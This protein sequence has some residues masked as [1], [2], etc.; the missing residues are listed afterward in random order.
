MFISH[1]APRVLYAA[2]DGATTGNCDSWANACTLQY[3][4]S[5][6]QNGDEIWVKA[7]VHY[8]GP[9]G[10]RMATF[11]LKSGVAIYGGFAGTESSR[12]ARDWQANPTVLSGDIDRNDRTDANGVVTTTAHITGTNAY[13]VVTAENVDS[14]AVLDGFIITA[15]KADG[16]Y[17]HSDGGGMYNFNSSP[18]LANVTFSGNSASKWGG[19]IY[20]FYKGSPTLTN[21]FFSGNSAAYGGGGICNTGSSTTLSSVIFNTNSAGNG[22]GMYNVRSNLTLT[23]VTFSGNYAVDGGG[24][25]NQG[26]SL[27]LINVIFSDNSARDLGGG[28]WNYKSNLTLSGVIFSGNRTSVGG[29]MYNS[30]S[31]LTLASITFSGNSAWRGG[32]VYNSNSSLTLTNITFS[33]NYATYGG[34]MYNS[35][36][37][38]MLTDITFSSNYSNAGGAI[39]NYYSNPMLTNVT[40]SRNTALNHGGGMYNDNSNPTL[41]NVIFSH[42]GVH[43]SGGAVYNYKSNPVLINA[44][45]NGNN[46]HFGG[47]IYNYSSDPHLINVILWGN[48]PELSNIDNSAPIISYS[49][50]R[51]CGSSGSGWKSECGVDGGGNIEADPL[52][53]DAAAGNLRLRPDSPAIDTGNEEVLLPTITTDLDKNPRISG[54]T[55]DMGAYEYQ[56]PNYYRLLV[57]LAG[58]GAGWVHSAP[59]HIACPS[60]CQRE[61]EIGAQVVLTATPGTTSQVAGWEGCD[62]VVGNICTLNMTA[63]RSVTVTFS[64]NPGILYAASIARGAGDCS[65]WANA[66]TLQI[67]LVSAAGGDEIWVE[68][69]V[70]YPGVAGTYTATITSFALKNGVAI[71]G[72]FAGTENNRDMRDWQA[73]LT[74]LSGDID[75]NDIT[76]ANGVVTTTTHLLGTNAYHVVT[77]ENVDNTAVLDGFIITAGQANGSYP[78]DKGGGMYNF[79]SNPTLR[80]I[81]FIGNSARDGGGMYNYNSN[82]TLTNVTFNNN[83]AAYGGGMHNWNSSPTLANSAF[84]DNF[85]TDGGGMHNWNS[86]PNLRNVIFTGNSATFGGGMYNNYSNPMLTDVTFNGNFADFGGGILNAASNPTLINISFHYN[87]GNGMYNFSSSPMLRNVI[88]SGNSAWSGGGVRND[89]SHPMLINVTFSHNFANYGGGMYNWCSNPTIINTT[90]SGNSAF[91]GGGMYNHSSDPHLINVILWGNTPELSN[92]D[93]SVP[94]ISYSDI[95]GCGGSGSGWKSECG[96]DGGGNI[97]ADPLFADAAAGN[98]RLRLTSP[99]IDAGDNTAVPTDIT[100]DLGG[101]PRFV[102]VPFV[103]DTGRGTPPIVDMGAYEAYIH[104]VYL[105]LIVRHY[106]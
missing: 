73:N 21:A 7:G 59:P 60:A 58:P 41:T 94:I 18:T 63:P 50:I 2:P 54:V 87:S 17:P 96:M 31:S 34:G 72:G 19:G 90:F 52:F 27:T 51:G 6:A 35:Y 67:A 29:G 99:C 8:P 4:L 83:S 12:D 71:Y 105:P 93:N 39:Y 15:G 57:N 81:T 88:F 49:D 89:Y 102:N 40:F 103:P 30:H 76:D 22:G 45:F 64:H 65:N 47:G 77:A 92:I 26:S 53:V 37:N 48:T 36:S 32:G 20:N 80:N 79:N 100:T 97:D 44:T 106:R 14:T 69:G 84:N 24:M 62:N 5:L 1:A 98:L 11:A 91:H 38:P 3:A 86:N 95:Q 85:A 56:S 43:E 61:F 28:M 13:H 42:N 70:H 74:I 101:N 10:D 75:H 25:Y 66:C 46:G 68:K 104:Q 78:Y 16:P 55:V 82:P 23:N 33:S 9:A